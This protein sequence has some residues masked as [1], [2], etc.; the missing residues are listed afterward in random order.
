[1]LFAGQFISEIYGTLLVYRASNLRR[2]ES[3]KLGHAIFRSM[4]RTGHSPDSGA[5]A[6]LLSATRLHTPEEKPTHAEVLSLPHPRPPF[7]HPAHI[8][9]H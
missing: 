6:S 1:M 5:L 8:Y 3:T 9:N 2:P 7:P 4:A